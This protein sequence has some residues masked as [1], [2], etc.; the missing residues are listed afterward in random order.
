[1]AD[2]LTHA[3]AC[4]KLLYGQ[5]SLW[6]DVVSFAV[7]RSGRRGTGRDA[8]FCSGI[9]IFSPGTGYNLRA[10]RSLGD[11]CF[12]GSTPTRTWNVSFEMAMGDSG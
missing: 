12:R 1:M 8:G 3:S 4:E 10:K 9:S 6:F 2:A 5:D 7:S 11:V